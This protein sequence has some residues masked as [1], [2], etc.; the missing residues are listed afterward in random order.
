MSILFG[1]IL[2]I[3]IYI[4]GLY[5]ALKFFAKDPKIVNRQYLVTSII[6]IILVIAFHV[7]YTRFVIFKGKDQISIKK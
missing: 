3:I 1:D 6:I 5:F 4:I 7:S 2:S